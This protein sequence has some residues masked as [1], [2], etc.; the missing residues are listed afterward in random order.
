MV[1]QKLFI[2]FYPLTN[3]QIE[4]I[5]QILEQYLRLYI[6]HQKNHRV[7]LLMFVKCV[8]NNLCHLSTDTG[9]FWPVI[10][11]IHSSIHQT[12]KILFA[13]LLIKMNL[14]VF[15]WS[16]SVFE[17]KKLLILK[18]PRRVIIIKTICQQGFYLVTKID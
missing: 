14:W 1:K 3:R 12:A 4:H 8:Y 16:L 11:F 13:I 6:N 10:S 18:I 7:T 9:F 5:N 2:A 15:A 17:F